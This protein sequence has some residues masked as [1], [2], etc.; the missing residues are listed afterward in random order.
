MER[1]KATHGQLRR[2]NRQLL[3][4]AVYS[5]VANSR[6]D[7]AHETGLA[8]PTVSDLIGTLIDEGY[9]VETGFGQSTDEGGKRPRLL[10]FVAEA[11]HII[12][13]SLKAEQVFGVL[14]NLDGHVVVQHYKNL[15][16]EQGEALLSIVREVINGLIA[17]L[18][19]PLLCIGVGV[20]GLVDNING[21]VKDAPYLNWQNVPLA[22]MLTRDYNVPVYIANSTELA[23]MAQFA[24]GN[25]QDA[26]NL[27]TVLVDDS[28]G[29]GFVLD[30]AAYHGGGE[31]GQLRVASGTDNQL[32]HLEAFL[33]W[34]YVKQRAMPLFAHYQ[35]AH[36]PGDD[37]TYLHIRKGVADN[38]PEAVALQDQMAEQLAE[39]FAWVIATLRPD[40]ISIAGSI[41]DMGHS[42]LDC[43]I[44][45]TR[46]RFLT[47]LVSPVT[48]SLDSSRNLVAI[49][50]VAQTL[51]K[52]LGVI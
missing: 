37:L 36:L 20:P 3:L 12:G 48:F 6:A 51:Q 2:E 46:A 18:H 17:Q 52:E 23:S 43:A 41:A 50:A 10:E 33:G 45:K 42:L 25:V 26:L 19:A 27:A 28:V 29:V 34:R 35:H 44:E 13:L 30:G 16:G 38:L 15:N 40:H 8:K 5:G 47:D 39:I 22:N 11:R 32:S 24:F 14:A 49:G 21:I 1:R 31:I 9:L 4:R 7:L